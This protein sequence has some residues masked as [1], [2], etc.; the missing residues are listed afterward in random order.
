MLQVGTDQGNVHKQR[1][2]VG[3][4]TTLEPGREVE[5]AYLLGMEE[6]KNR[7]A[8]A[9]KVVAKKK[10]VVDKLNAVPDYWYKHDAELHG[11]FDKLRQT[12]AELLAKGIQDPFTDQ[13]PESVAFRKE[14]DRMNQLATS[15]TQMREHYKAI[16]TKIDDSGP[17][18]FDD[19][20]LI[21]IDNFYN[22][23]L[24]DIVSKGMTPPNLIKKRPYLEAFDFVGKNMGTWSQGWN[25]NIPNDA[26]T[27][28]FVRALVDDPANKDKVVRAYGSKLAQMSEL[29]RADVEA[30]AKRTGMDTHVIMAYDDANRWKKMQGPFKPLEELA[31]AAETVESGINYVSSSDPNRSSTTFSKQDMEKALD[32]VSM[33]VFND[34]PEWMEYYADRVERYDDESDGAYAKRV[35]AKIKEDIRPLVGTKT[36]FGI[37]EKGKGDQEKVVGRQQWIKDLRS[38]D[39]ILQD[40]AAQW[41]VGSNLM[42]NLDVETSRVRDFEGKPVLQIE[43]KTNLTPKEIKEEVE[44]QGGTMSEVKVISNIEGFKTLVVPL[45]SESVANQWLASAYD[46]TWKDRG[47]T[48]YE[49]DIS[50]RTQKSI[51]NLD[52]VQVPLKPVP[53]KGATQ[54]FKKN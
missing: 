4:G 45:D 2:G 19:K 21:D 44:G 50:E 6:R 51:D 5:Y 14:Y 54:F 32:T 1:Q 25:G 3:L 41:I 46:T 28:D 38:G 33:A 39:P 35:M 40:A 34:R 37:T 31:K 23:P 16:R 13:S 43:L 15:S 36:S 49:T 17:D 48:N 22:T 29:E 53:L 27:L 24:S 42:Q 52:K 12:G 30:R 9:D 10:E 18:D 8:A 47:K 20:A 26:Q 11:G 7:R